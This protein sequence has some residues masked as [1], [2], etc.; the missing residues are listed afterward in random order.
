MMG[1][2]DA[3]GEVYEETPRMERADDRAGLREFA[4]TTASSMQLRGRLSYEAWVGVGHQIARVSN[5]SA[6]WLGD[7]ILYGEQEYGMR[8][9]AALDATQLDYQTLRNYAWVA[10]R[11]EPSRRRQSVSL[12]HHAEVARLP[13]PDQDLWLARAARLRWSRNE[14]RRQLRAAGRAE[15]NASDN[16][17]LT[18]HVPV[19]TDRERL[20]RQAAAAAEQELV[21]WVAAAADEAAEAALCSPS[22][23]PRPVP[24]QFRLT[25]SAARNAGSRRH[26]ASVRG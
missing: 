5:A 4:H 15:A 17:A 11:F 22:S 21:D 23:R 19:P 14:L 25:R 18:L 16:S 1:E 8:Y 3:N 7:W 26:S 9:K 2:V 6:W 13:E 24:I 10:R 20:W 12:Q